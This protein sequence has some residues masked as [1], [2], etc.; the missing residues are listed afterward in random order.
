MSIL[1]QQF[2][3][4]IDENSVSSPVI[5]IK[6]DQAPI[7]DGLLTI[8]PSNSERSDFCRRADICSEIQFFELLEITSH[9]EKV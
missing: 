9:C 7:G 6:A 8:S 3:V 5:D 2:Y 4:W 1:S